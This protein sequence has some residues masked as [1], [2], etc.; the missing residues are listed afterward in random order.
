M[1]CVRL[2]S[3]TAPFGKTATTTNSASPAEGGLATAMKPTVARKWSPAAIGVGRV[4]SPLI[5][6]WLFSTHWGWVSR[7][8]GELP[9]SSRSELAGRMIANPRASVS[10][11][12]NGSAPAPLRQVACA[13]WLIREN[14]GVFP[15]DTVRVTGSP[16]IA[17]APPAGFW[18]MMLPAGTVLLARFTA[19][20]TSPTAVSVWLATA[21]GLLT[22]SGTVTGFGATVT[23]VIGSDAVADCPPGPVAFT[24]T[25]Y[26]CATPQWC[27]VSRPV[28]PCPSP[29]VHRAPVGGPPDTAVTL[30]VTSTPTGAVAV[31]TEIATTNGARGRVGGV[32]VG[33]LGV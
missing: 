22:T 2:S 29:K 7:N 15:L 26:V 31:D 16:G 5:Q 30:S 13:A 32:P 33:E 10:E 8:C 9:S 17:V 24:A 23:T 1:S 28:A 18:A 20:G 19:V 12:G 4:K 21:T 11:P 14:G 25:W 6:P 27:A 3:L